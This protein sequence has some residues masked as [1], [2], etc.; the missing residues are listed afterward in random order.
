MTTGYYL[1]KD[2][3][4]QEKNVERNGHSTH[5]V[6]NLQATSPTASEIPTSLR[7]FVI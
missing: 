5:Y 6:V 4:E 7:R 2:Q 3:Q 1:C